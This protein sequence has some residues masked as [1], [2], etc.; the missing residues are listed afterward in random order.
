MATAGTRKAAP[1]TQEVCIDLPGEQVRC[2]R[3][4]DKIR[5]VL[6]K[7]RDV[8]VDVS[9]KPGTIYILESKSEFYNPILKKLVKKIEFL[10][11]DRFN[12]WIGREF[13]GTLVLRAG[14]RILGTYEVNELDKCRYGADPKIKPEPLMIVIGKHAA[15]AAFYSVDDPLGLKTSQDLFKQSLGAKL[16]LLNGFATQFDYACP[17]DSPDVQD[18]AVVTDVAV[19]D[20]KPQIVAQLE[21]G[22][23]A[24]GSVGE[25]FLPPRNTEESS[26]LYRA[27]AASLG[28]ISG[29]PLF[30]S[31]ITKESLGY[32]MENFKA[33]DQLGMTAH[34]EKKK[35]GMY[36]AVLRGHKLTSI[37]AHK[38]RGTPLGR[39]PTKSFPL[40]SNSSAFIDGGF[41]RT[42]KAGC[43]GVRRMF[44]TSAKNFKSGMKIQVIGTIID[45]IVD[46]DTVFFDERGSKDL[47][48]F[49]GRA[50]AFYRQ[51]RCDSCDRKHHR[52]GRGWSPF[53]SRRAV[54][55]YCGCGSW[56]IHRCGDAC[57]LD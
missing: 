4:S 57:R 5:V 34:L 49:L 42:G 33:L 8:I 23:S 27:I 20:I 54:G 40:G 22:G 37:L 28:F 48:E 39:P 16:P 45:I 55:I 2:W 24:S 53:G 31:N 26:T 1:T 3:S 36:R 12:I 9:L 18:Y 10:D 32:L 29:N 14:Q 47:S 6:R 35:K 50:G 19:H 11:G 38:L 43:G 13:K 17:S 41:K 30:T 25:I 52:C 15:T 51:S 46:A 7:H 44:I 21:R 56:W